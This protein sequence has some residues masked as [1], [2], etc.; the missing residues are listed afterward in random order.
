MTAMWRIQMSRIVVFGF[1]MA[2]IVGLAMLGERGADAQSTPVP[3]NDEAAVRAV[4][5]AQL[6]AWAAGDG[7][8]FAATVTEDSDLIAFDGTHLVGRQE[9]ASF[10]QMQFDTVLAGIQVVAEPVRIRFIGDDSVV[11]ITRGGV[12]FPGEI[13]VPAE[14]D[15]I[16]TFVLTKQDGRW[17]VEAFQN[18]RIAPAQT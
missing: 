6:T 4:L 5:E 11:M 8:A 7:A 3:G 16:Q 14:R 1:V 13:E 15:S 12:I 18:T 10:M 17:L 9:I 2:V